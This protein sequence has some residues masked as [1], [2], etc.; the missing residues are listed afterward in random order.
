M[1]FSSKLYGQNS[2]GI[3]EL[4]FR[5]YSKKIKA[6]ITMAS[7]DA[8]R[9]QSDTHSPAS[10]S[11]YGLLTLGATS[12]APGSRHDENAMDAESTT[13]QAP[14][15]YGGANTAD[16]ESLPSIT[17]RFPS[18]HSEVNADGLVAT[19]QENTPPQLATSSRPS[20]GKQLNKLVKAPLPLLRLTPRQAL[21][22]DSPEQDSH[23]PEAQPSM[24]AHAR[25]S[26]ITSSILHFPDREEK[27]E[28]DQKAAFDALAADPIHGI[29][30][31]KLRGE[32][33]VYTS[34][35]EPHFVDEQAPPWHWDMEGEE[36]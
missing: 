18:L 24:E 29:K 19:S 6:D 22:A 33:M 31:H 7:A 12:R 21:P 35:P 2:Q 26:S 15:R 30:S 13:P 9:S 8:R 1:L 20:F 25:R 23:Y 32:D 5:N 16:G 17:P 3:A 14:S 34:F 11:L 28:I 4:R 27:H 36:S 10:D